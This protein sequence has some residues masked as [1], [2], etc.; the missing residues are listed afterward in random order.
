MKCHPTTDTQLTGEKLWTDLLNRTENSFLGY[1]HCKTLLHIT[2]SEF[3]HFYK[4]IEINI[5]PSF[6]YNLSGEHLLCS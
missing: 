3:Y 1:S 4:N 2:V 6:K 5:Q